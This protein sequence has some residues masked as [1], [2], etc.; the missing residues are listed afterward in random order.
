MSMSW[1]MY[2]QPELLALSS[3]NCSSVYA[4]S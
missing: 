4:L 1:K 2:S 3:R